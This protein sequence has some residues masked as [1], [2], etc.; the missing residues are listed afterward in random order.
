MTHFGPSEHRCIQGV[1][2]KDRFRSCAQL[3][4]KPSGVMMPRSF[5]FTLF[6]SW[7]CIQ[8]GYAA[9]HGSLVDERIHDRDLH[10]ED[11]S[12]FS[13]VNVDFTNADL[14]GAD[15]RGAT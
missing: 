8:L 1:S 14:T 9:D 12:G 5:V 2:L 3:G 11:F 15:F 7:L 4:Q 6:I 10:G 13:M